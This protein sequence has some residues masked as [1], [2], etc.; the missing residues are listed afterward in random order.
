MDLG[1]GRINNT[2][3][4]G[5]ARFHC[6]GRRLPL[7]VMITVCIDCFFYCGSFYGGIV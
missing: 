2:F 1:F 3:F 7:S 5:T 6:V 4:C